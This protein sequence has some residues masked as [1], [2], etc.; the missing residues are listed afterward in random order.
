[1][2]CTQAPDPGFGL[3][4]RIRDYLFHVMLAGDRLLVD[5]M[6]EGLHFGHGGGAGLFHLFNTLDHLR[7][8]HAVHADHG[9]LGRLYDLLIAVNCQIS[10]GDVVEQDVAFRDIRGTFE[11]KT[12]DLYREARRRISLNERK[13]AEPGRVR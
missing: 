6:G 4:D 11:R 9:V 5:L 13:R 7:L 1:M 8:Q 3:L 12:L 2:I 10:A